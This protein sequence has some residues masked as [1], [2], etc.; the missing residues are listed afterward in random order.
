MRSRPWETERKP[1]T[2][3]GK[4]GDEKK[5]PLPGVTVLLKGM[6]LGVTNWGRGGDFF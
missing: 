2:G 4:V 6:T 5:Q 3:R 1:V